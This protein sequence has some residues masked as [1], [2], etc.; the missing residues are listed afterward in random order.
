MD[1]SGST[2]STGL[3][4]LLNTPPSSLLSSTEVSAPLPSSPSSSFEKK[5]RPLK[6]Y[7]VEDGNML[8]PYQG[9]MKFQDYLRDR[10]YGNY[11]DDHP[12]PYYDFPMHRSGE[13]ASGSYLFGFPHVLALKR[14]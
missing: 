9:S 8:G 7:R 10:Y 5:A 1:I 14:W 6:V 4:E 12:D 2:C 11:L 3:T 13:Y